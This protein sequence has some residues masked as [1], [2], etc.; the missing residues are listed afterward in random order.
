MPGLC[1][2]SLSLLSVKRRTSYPVMTEQVA[3]P[4]AALVHAPPKTKARGRR[5]RPQGSKNRNRRAVALSPSLRF[6]QEHIKRLLAQIG[7]AFTVVDFLCDGERG[8]ND[9]MHMVRQVGRHLLSKLRSNAALY[10][11]YEGP[12]CGRGP[13]RKYG[14]KVDSHHIPST[15]LQ[16]IAMDSLP[17]TFITYFDIDI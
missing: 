6:I 9:A 11:P 15:Y 10:F 7:D 13:R 16:S 12:Y 8:H 3:K 14:Q 4:S 1:F 2:L 5:G 17:D